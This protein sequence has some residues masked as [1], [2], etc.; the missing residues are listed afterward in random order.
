MGCG[1]CV[2]RNSLNYNYLDGL[3]WWSGDQS[4]AT[5]FTTTIL[6]RIQLLTS[7]SLW[8]HV[9]LGVQKD[10]NNVNDARVNPFQK[11]LHILLLDFRC[12]QCDQIGGFI[13]LWA[14]FKAFGK[15]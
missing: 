6:V 8:L 3:L 11:C 14:N 4:S 7:Q 10:E 5:S 9:V 12:V 1:F 2:T 15:N 13:G